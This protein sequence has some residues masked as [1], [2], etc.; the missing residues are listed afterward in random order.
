[1]LPQVERPG[2]LEK[3]IT[4][5]QAV[6][7]FLRPF[8]EQNAW[9][10]VTFGS[11]WDNAAAAATTFFPAAFRMDPLG[12][13]WFRGEVAR[14]A[15]AAVAIVILP[16]GMRPSRDITLSAPGTG[17]IIV[18]SSGSIEYV[19]AAGAASVSLG[20]VSYDTRS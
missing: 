18:R 12:R 5:V 1:M 8:D 19:G 14:A 10:P 6:L 13:V 2:S 15:G 17:S 9:R 7:K 4:A 11:T 16:T 3:L 20:A